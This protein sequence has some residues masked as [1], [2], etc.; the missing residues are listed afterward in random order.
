M[1]KEKLADDAPY[2]LQKAADMVQEFMLCVALR[3]GWRLIRAA[4]RFEAES[5][6]LKLLQIRQGQPDDAASR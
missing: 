6:L 2:E 1:L 3:D 4:C 5:L